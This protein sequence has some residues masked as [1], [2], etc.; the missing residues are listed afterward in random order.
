LKRSLPVQISTF[1]A[2]RLV[3]N[4]GLR[5][6]YPFLPIFARGLGVDLVMMSYALTLRAASGT[7]GPF[8]ASVADSRGR[9]AGML[10][11]LGLF[12][13]GCAAVAI[14][15]A[16][17]VFTAALI[18]G[19][20]GNLTFAPSMQAHLGDEV[21]YSRRGLVLALTEL[22]WSLALII[23]VPLVGLLIYRRGWQAPFPVLAG[24]GLLAIAAIFWLLPKD[25]APTEAR[26]GIWRNLRS[27]FT[28]PPAL[29][30]VSIGLLISGSNEMVNVVFGVWLED[31]FAVRIAALAV[32]SAVIGFSE[33]GGEVLSA[34]LTDR[35]GK[36]RTVTIGL[37]LNILAALCLPLLGRSLNGALVGLFLVY[38]AFEFTVVSS[39]PLMSEVLPS[40]R[41]T[42]MA[43][44]FA[45][46]ALGRAFGAFIAPRLYAL[47]GAPGAPSGMWAVVPASAL[48]IL[49]AL[50]AL[51]FLTVRRAREASAGEGAV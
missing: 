42:L 40:A 20:A 8:L 25:I 16:F 15:P 24:L 46:S 10:F 12:V 26:P 21:P 33:L 9:R 6:V 29:A 27:V 7:F 44:F 36:E 35:L 45:G 38:C 47:G 32:A 5:M 49:L 34:G 50:L 48:L 22:G 17:A 37:L 19:L 11:G 1:V 31:A 23:G 43:T 51:R 2:V 30:G 4:T 13:A 39:M 41:A 28:Y 18:L 14:W 3:M